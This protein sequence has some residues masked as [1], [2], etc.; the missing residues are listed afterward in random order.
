MVTGTSWSGGSFKLYVPVDSTFKYLST[1]PPNGGGDRLSA[2]SVVNLRNLRGDHITDVV[3]RF[4][5]G[6]THTHRKGL[7]G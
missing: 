2:H 4:Y 5:R 1:P 7:E 6:D 3:V